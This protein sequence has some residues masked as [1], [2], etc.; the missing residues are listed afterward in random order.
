MERTVSQLLRPASRIAPLSFSW[1]SPSQGSVAGNGF[2]SRR[3]SPRC[4]RPAAPA[5]PVAA[6]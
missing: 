6:P 5:S 3:L 1:S 4:W 2:A